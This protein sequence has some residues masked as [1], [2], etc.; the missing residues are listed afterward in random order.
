MEL[1]TIL[2][3]LT[4]FT[5]GH[6]PRKA[7]QAAIAQREAITPH[8][9]KSLENAP[10]VLGRM[11]ADD[12]YMLP[13]YAFYLLAQFR[14]PR[15]YPLIVDFFSLPGESPLDMTGDFVTEDLGRVLASV[16]GGNMAPMKRLVRNPRINEFTRG[17]ALGGLVSLFVND[18]Q[19]REAVIAYLRHL[20]RGGLEQKYSYVWEGLLSTCASLCAEELLEDL[21]QAADKDL[22]EDFDWFTEVMSQ[23]KEARL[24]SLRNDPHHQLVADTVAEIEWWA[25]FR[26]PPRP[27]VIT[28]KPAPAP[29]QKIGRNAPCPCGSGKKYK[30]CCGKP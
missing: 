30:H 16:S 11:V 12:N 14:E 10:R 2:E 22:F 23:G 28:P 6:F 27:P 21:Q 20:L 4:T 15:A 25:C 24:A 7:L 19:P 8:L 13:L 29:G 5:S 3:E 26:P 17:A 18:L 9:L 1:E